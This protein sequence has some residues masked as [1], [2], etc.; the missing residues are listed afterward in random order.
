MY[1][2]SRT[3]DKSLF[4]LLHDW[5]RRRFGAENRC[6]RSR[7]C[8]VVQSRKGSK[9]ARASSVYKV[10]NFRPIEVDNYSQNGPENDQRGERHRNGEKQFESALFLEGE[11]TFFV[12]ERRAFDRLRQFAEE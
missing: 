12:G 5:R 1:I 11:T 10:A 9:T 8:L 6:L 2:G 7:F 3:L 4:L